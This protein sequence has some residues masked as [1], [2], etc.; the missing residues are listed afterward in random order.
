MAVQTDLQYLF[1]HKAIVDAA[2][3]KGL[4]DKSDK[5]EVK[6]FNKE[7]DL[8]MNRKREEKRAAANKMDKKKAK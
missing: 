6:A 5:E 2:I 8:L 7:Y 4:I 1:V 3:W